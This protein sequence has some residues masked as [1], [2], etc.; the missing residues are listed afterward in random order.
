MAAASCRI[1]RHVISPLGAAPISP[2]MPLPAEMRCLFPLR[3]CA[4]ISLALL[5]PVR[6]IAQGRL[7]PL[8]KS[9]ISGL[10]RSAT[11]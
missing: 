5:P 7:L 9:Q 6:A 4:A 8:R 10:M 2:P 11:R 1:S 3:R